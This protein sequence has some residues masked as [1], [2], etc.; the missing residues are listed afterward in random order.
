[1]VPPA[2]VEEPHTYR[3]CISISISIILVSVTAAVCFILL[4]IDL[5]DRTS[6]NSTIHYGVHL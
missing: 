4:N 2:V 6:T 5:E 3:N 1:M